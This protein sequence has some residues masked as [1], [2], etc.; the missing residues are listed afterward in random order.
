MCLWELTFCPA[1]GCVVSYKVSEICPQRQGSKPH[2]ARA[3]NTVEITLASRC[4][5]CEVL[6]NMDIESNHSTSLHSSGSATC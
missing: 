6:D 5:R 1:R 2:P 4:A 3:A